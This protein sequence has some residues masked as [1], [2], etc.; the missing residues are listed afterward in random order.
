LGVGLL[1]V[2]C[3]ISPALGD[4]P[5]GDKVTVTFSVSVVDR[6]N[7]S[8]GGII[9]AAVKVYDNGKIAGQGLTNANGSAIV[10]VDVGR[11]DTI[12]LKTTVNFRNASKTEVAPDTG[13]KDKSTLNLT[14]SLEKD[15]IL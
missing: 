13:W 15:V 6:Y 10:T 7:P 3:L 12:L 11:T 5:A 9:G 14:L 8:A 1:A 2:A 4:A